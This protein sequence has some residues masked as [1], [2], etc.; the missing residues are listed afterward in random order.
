MSSIPA[1]VVDVPVELGGSTV[2]GVTAGAGAAARGDELVVRSAAAVGGGVG[3]RRKLD[4][5]MC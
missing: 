5:T 1:N 4:C 2:A 3:E